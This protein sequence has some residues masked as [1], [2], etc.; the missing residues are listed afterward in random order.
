M[1]QQVR[2]SLRLRRAGWL[3][4][5]LALLLA[6]F[7]LASPASPATK[8]K[9]SPKKIVIGV[10]GDISSFNIYT[11]TTAFSQEII[12]LVH[13]R[14]AEEQDDFRNGPPS[15]KPALATSWELSPDRATLTFHLDPHARWSDGQPLTS[16]DVLFSHKAAASP[17][18]GWV[19][20][21]VKEAIAA[22]ATPDPKTIVF[23]FSK[24]YPYQLMDAV[25]GNVI[26]AHFY[27]ST[28]LAEWPKKAFL[29]TP[30]ASGP[31]LVKRYEHG[32]LIELVRNPTY[33]RAPLPRLDDV[34]FRIIPDE[35]TLLNELLAGGIDVMENLPEAAVKKVE[36]SPRLRIVRVPDLSYTFI[37]WNTGRPLFADARVR[38]ALTLAIDRTAII[39]GLLRATGRPSAGPILSFMWAADPTLKPLPYD[40]DGARA[41]L[42]EA[43]WA[44]SDSDGIL[45]RQ[46]VPFRLEL[47]TNQGSGLRSDIVQMVSAQLKKVGIEAVPRIIEY[48]AFIAGHEKHEYDAFVSSWRESTKVDLK[49]VYHSSAIASGYNYGQYANPELDK[50]IDQARIESDREAA[51][52]LWAQAQAIIVRDQPVTFLFERDRLH[53]LPKNLTGFHSSPRSAY[54]G[55][56]D[57]SIE[58][59]APKTP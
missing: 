14:L 23:S 55:L 51:R 18:V 27:Q 10:R 45:D 20:S 59:K 16:A 4:A 9:T 52:K 58:A 1:F 33:F 36:A 34:I 12:D 31:F 35:T 37:S 43:G 6:F 2:P 38:R 44:D 24:P 53:A 11:A 15:F 7:S 28:P 42:K 50:V 57:W 22:A 32:S 48:G 25:E 3:I 8:S 19:G 56:E 29:E 13:V 49:S 46:G 17:D 47:E 30:P 21:D 39:E 5:P 41:L 54:V 40:P 26:P